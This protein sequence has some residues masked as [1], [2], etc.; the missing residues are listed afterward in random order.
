MRLTDLAIRTLKAPD[1]GA[2][3]YPDDQLAGF[4]VRVSQ[5]GTASYVLTHGAARER[6]TLG[7]VG[8]LSLKD[9]RAEARRILAEETLGKHRPK[10]LTFADAVAAFVADKTQKNRPRTIL[11]NERLLKKYESPHLG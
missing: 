9:A 7:R 11:E 5:A 10:R 3:V 4:G 1:T 6:V 2:R 8:I